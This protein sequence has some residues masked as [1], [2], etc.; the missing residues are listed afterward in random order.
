VRLGWFIVALAVLGPFAV[1]AYGLRRISTGRRLLTFAAVAGAIA[2]APLA[3]LLA[4][5]AYAGL[6][7]FA[8]AWA[9]GSLYGLLIGALALA[10]RGVVFS[11]R[12]RTG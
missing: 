12:D 2:V 11:H 6:E 9:V 1:V 3:L 7:L 4:L 10:L 8:G 5:G